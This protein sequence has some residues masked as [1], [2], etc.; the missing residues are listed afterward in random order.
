MLGRVISP[1][2]LDLGSL[3][4][5][6]NIDGIIVPNTLIYLG[7]AIN[8]MTTEAMLKLNLQGALRKTTTVLQLADISIIAPNRVIE[9]VMVFIYPWE[10]PT[11][12]LVLLPK[13]KCNGYPLILGRPWFA[14]VDAYISCRARNMTIKKGG[15]SK[16]IVLYPPTHHF[17]ENDFPL[18]LENEEEE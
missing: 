5:D 18:L 13:T 8:V 9:D 10:Y 6:V 2:Y 17:V 14:T 11:N 15:L 1:K 4:V 7:D 16:Q 12:F 3:V